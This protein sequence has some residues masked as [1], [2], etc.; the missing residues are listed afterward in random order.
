MITTNDLN[1]ETIQILKDGIKQGDMFTIALR[2]LNNDF[3]P[4]DL[5]NFFAKQFK[6]N[7]EFCNKVVYNAL[8]CID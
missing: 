5:I 4:A 7:K 8:T 1:K 3:Q 2:M 6:I